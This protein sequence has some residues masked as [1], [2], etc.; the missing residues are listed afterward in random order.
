M[1]W[2]NNLSYTHPIHVAPKH[3]PNVAA[4]K[5]KY[6]VLMGNLRKDGNMEQFEEEWLTLLSNFGYNVKEFT[7]KATEK[8]I[9]RFFQG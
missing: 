9:I 2:G 4:L 1:E 8:C 5:A 3:K 7:P 6:K